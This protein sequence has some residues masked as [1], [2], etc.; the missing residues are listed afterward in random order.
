MNSRSHTH[1]R[2]TGM[3]NWGTGDTDLVEAVLTSPSGV[4]EIALK[5]IVQ[6]AR[7]TDIAVLPDRQPD[8]ACAEIIF[9]KQTFGFLRSAHAT[10]EQLQPWAQW[11]ARWLALD[12]RYR[13]Y[14]MKSFQDDLTGAWNRRFF[15]SFLRD[16]S[17]ARA[18]CAAKSA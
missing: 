10:L 6:Q 14:R 9:N 5:L 15:E 4:R 16:Q 3:G 8:A 7:W 18:S 11:L 13:E 12:E 1:R 2:D 17:C